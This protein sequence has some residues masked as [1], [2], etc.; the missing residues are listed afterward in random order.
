M[1]SAVSARPRATTEKRLVGGGGLVGCWFSFG[2]GVDVEDGGDDVGGGD[3]DGL[4]P[5]LST[6]ASEE[7]LRPKPAENRRVVMVPAAHQ[8]CRIN[9]PHLYR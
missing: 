5:R 2:A 9:H 6:Q 3:G 8:A 4:K 1:S 7:R